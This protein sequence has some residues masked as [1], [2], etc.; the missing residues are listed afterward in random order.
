MLFLDAGCAELLTGQEEG[1]AHDLATCGLPLE[2]V[3]RTS[4]PSTHGPVEHLA[5]QCPRG[6]RY[7]HVAPPMRRADAEADASAFDEAA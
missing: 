5:V 3:G 6:H 2:V 1:W 4:L 7:T